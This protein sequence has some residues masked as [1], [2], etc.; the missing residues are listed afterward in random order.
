MSDVIHETPHSSMSYHASDM[1][2]LQD[3]PGLTA[4]ERED[5][6]LSIE[7]IVWTPSFCESI[8]IDHLNTRVFYTLLSKSEAPPSN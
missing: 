3:V 8:S 4:Y 7:P 5:H 6:Q 1:H 2:V